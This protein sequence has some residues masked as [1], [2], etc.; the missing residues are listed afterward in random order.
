VALTP[1][2]TLPSTVVP[3]RVQVA[4]AGTL[5]S[6]TA[7][8]PMV[9]LQLP[10]GTAFCRDGELDVVAVTVIVGAGFAL[11]LFVG[12]LSSLVTSRVTEVPVNMNPRNAFARFGPGRAGSVPNRDAPWRVQCGGLGRY[13]WS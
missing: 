11:A 4:P 1:T 8:P 3:S 2:E 7:T 5:T 9:P 13:C 10:A 12:P 6:S